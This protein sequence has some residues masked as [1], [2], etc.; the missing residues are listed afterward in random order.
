MKKRSQDEWRKLL[1]SH[2]A[3]G[4]SARQFC[5]ERQLCPKYFSL[6]KKQLGLREG[7]SPFVRARL[8]TVVTHTAVE[9]NTVTQALVFRQGKGS[10]HFSILPDLEWLARLLSAVA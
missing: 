7:E 6:R 2:T 9:E 5:R 1:A 8:T 4:M 10:L 3:S